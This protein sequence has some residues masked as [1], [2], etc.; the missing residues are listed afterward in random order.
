MNKT[1]NVE[2]CKTTEHSLS[3]GAMMSYIINYGEKVLTNNKAQSEM[4]LHMIKED[5]GGAVSSSKNGDTEDTLINLGKLKNPE[6]IKAIYSVIHA[7]V[8]SLKVDANKQN[9]QLR[10]KKYDS[11]S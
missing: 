6:N 9:G 4:I 1:T 3:I 5:E 7:I 8:E 11:A 2:E 10:T